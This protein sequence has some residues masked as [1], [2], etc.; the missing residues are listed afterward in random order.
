MLMA[1]NDEVLKF[2]ALCAK[3]RL[4]TVIASF[5]S[6]NYRAGQDKLRI[7]YDSYGEAETKTEQT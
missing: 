4:I 7:Q 3:A 5:L 6:E 1:S 2:K